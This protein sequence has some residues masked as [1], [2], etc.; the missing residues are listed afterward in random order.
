MNFN[1]DIGSIDTLQT[2]DSSS[3]PPLGGV[4][5]VF[6]V[7][8]TGALIINTGTVLQRPSVPAVGMIRV[9]SDAGL[10]EFWDG[11]TWVSTG[12]Q[13]TVTS[14][15][16]VGSTG[17]STAGGPVTSTGT[18]TITLNTELQ[19]L[20]ALAALGVIAR[21]SAGV[22]AARTIGGTA[23]NI[24]VTNGDGVSGNPTV[25]LATVGAGATSV[26]SSTS[27][28]VVSYD[29]F[30]RVTAAVNT[31]IAFPVTSVFGRTGVV[32]AI[33]GDYTLG[34]IG[35]I[36]LS[37]PAAG[38]ILTYNGS[39]W[40]NSAPATAGTVTSI[41][42]T[43]S[44]GLAVSG[45]PIT[46]AGTIGLTLAAELQGLSGLASSGM[47]ARTGAGTYTS[48][49]IAGTATRTIVT[50][51]DGVAGAPTIDLAT[52]SAGVGGTFQKFT[53]DAYGR[54]SA[55]NP[56][57]AADITTLVDSV[58]VNVIGDS[59][60]GNL[61]FTGGAT[62]T[63]LPT[64]VNSGDATPKSYVDA[65]VTG[66]SWKQAA[67]AAT[68]V[69]GVF[70]T[71]F[72]N[73]SIIDG[74]TLATGDRILIKNQTTASENGIYTVNATGTPTRATDSDSPSEMVGGSVF[75]DSGTINSDTGWVLATN[76][77]IVLGTT[78]LVYSQFSG[79]GSYTA[80][81]GLTLIGNVFSLSSPVTTA[82]GGT[83]LSTIGTANQVLGVNGAGTALE[84]KT[85]TAG[86]GISIV[87][88]SGVVTV[89]NTGVLSFTQSVPSIFAISGATASTGAVNSAI[90]LA[91]QAA[92]TV[93]AAPVSSTGTPTF[94]ALA[95]TDLPIA[96]YREN[97]V[98]PVT[99]LVAGVN[100]V[101][102]GSGASAS[103]LR[104]IAIGNN[105]VAAL[106]GSMAIANG[107][108]A[109][110][111]DAQEL[112]FVMYNTTSSATTT[113]LF[114]DGVTAT[115]RAL[116]PNNSLWT[117]SMLVSARRTDATG[118]GAGY[119]FEGVIKKDA[120]AASTGLIG[121]PSKAVLGESN[122]GWDAAVSADT[123]NG[124]LRVQVTGEAAKTIR[125]VATVII[126]QVTN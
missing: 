96:L 13:G 28:P 70:A 25:N 123:T 80:G 55:V 105:S 104:S 49:T 97:P 100:A 1:H 111:G 4:A 57:L 2:I 122:V 120:T 18:I 108:F 14:V 65:A 41:A 19:G 17:V 42:V 82:L 90:T 81:T 66:L 74:I 117:F 44:T 114:L 54:V 43:G 56:V 31:P 121:T 99:P 59:M 20:S 72:A 9:N 126:S 64:P 112:K 47:I 86:A 95:F 124:T 91:T 125:W 23:S 22:Y 63:G 94:R 84:Y 24:V 101:A 68:T 83:G 32:S 7:I 52:L 119:K 36:L 10:L 92:G 107:G 53:T 79:A 77:P 34:Q 45:S 3:L 67:R 48:R 71:S 85:N 29:T 8:G 51:G 50:N 12:K 21:T 33:A 35:T 93:F 115:I 75:I 26:G 110:A 98:T 113:E 16:V 88:A 60:S 109:S 39:N 6:Q 40:I 37:A 46:S 76:A 15:A 102:I 73:G 62:I 27:V 106:Q 61:A 87:N 118:G 11:V 30:G 5:G 78:A 38:N 103:A 116:M 58:Y 69:N 89:A